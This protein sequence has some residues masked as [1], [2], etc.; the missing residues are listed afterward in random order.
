M[1]RT[2]RSPTL[3]AI[4][5]PKTLHLIEVA[6]VIVDPGYVEENF[7]GELETLLSKDVLGVAFQR[8]LP[9]IKISGT[10]CNRGMQS[11]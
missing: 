1:T 11:S 4:I 10:F 3:S 7:D 2:H 9:N 5:A 8:K 6:T